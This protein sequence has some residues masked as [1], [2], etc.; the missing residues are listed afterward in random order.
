MTTY[1]RSEDPFLDVER[2]PVGG[3][4]PACGAARLAAYPVL[5]ER[6]WERVVK[7]QECLTSVS[8]ERWHLLGGIDL[9][10]DLSRGRSGAEPN[11]RSKA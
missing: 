1:Q 4:C 11:V 6:G 10:V 9:G 2:S 7:C 3:D 8:R 5:S